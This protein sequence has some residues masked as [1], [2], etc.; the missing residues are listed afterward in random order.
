VG[1]ELE[2][3]LLL[4]GDCTLE[5]LARVVRVDVL[6]KG[7]PARCDVALEFLDLPVTEMGRLSEAM[8][9]HAP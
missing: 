5:L 9:E 7:A 3:E 4:P 2:L 1:A 6:P 8:E